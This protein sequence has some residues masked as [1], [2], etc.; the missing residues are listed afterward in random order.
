MNYEWIGKAI[1][2]KNSIPKNIK[3]Q[4]EITFSRMREER[5]EPREVKKDFTQNVEKEAK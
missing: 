2:K 1:K 3:K 5:N 4:S